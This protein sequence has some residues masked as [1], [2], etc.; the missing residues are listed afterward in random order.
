MVNQVTGT[1][2]IKEQRL[3]KYHTEICKLLPEFDECQLDQIPQAQNIEADGLAKST[4]ATKNFTTEDQSKV[5]LLN[6]LIDQIKVRNVNLTW[7]WRNRIAT[8]LQDGIL[9]NDKKEAKKLWMQAA[10]Y[11]IVHNDL[12]KRTY[13][14]PLAKCLDPNQT[15]RVLEEVHE[16]HCGAHSGNQ[17][18]VRCLI[19]AGYYRPAM[20]KKAANFVKNC[21]R[22]QKYAPMIHQAGAY[23]QIHEQEV[24]AFIWKNITCRFCLPKEINCDNGPEFAGKKVAEFFEN[25][26]SKEYCQRLTTPQATE[27]L[28]ACR[29]T[30]KV[31][32]GDA[33]IPVE[34][35]EPSLRYFR[36]SGSQNDD[37]RRQELDEIEERRDMAYVRMVAHKQQA[38]RYYNKRA[39]IGPLK[40]GAYMLKDKTQA[41]KDPR[42][43]KLGTNWDDPYKITTAASKGSFTL[44][45]MEGK[46]L[47]NNWNITHLRYFNF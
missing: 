42:E 32:T 29:T 35:G 8:Y 36:E 26:T 45:T 2:Q 33:V 28:W 15:R 30:P 34:V 19:R 16:G 31:S 14:G 24:I 38:K 17:V 21:E 23:A 20:K 11:S 43:G 39:K 41:S 5:H 25:G 9:P 13:G 47:P 18:L 22:C 4:A 3:Q 6:S 10:R 27:V 1:F 12:Y 40:V 46:R 37:S 7:D 44:E